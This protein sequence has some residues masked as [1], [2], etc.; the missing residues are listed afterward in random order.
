MFGDCSMFGFISEV[1]GKEIVFEE[2]EL[3]LVCENLF[4]YLEVG[5]IFDDN[6]SRM[7]REVFDCVKFDSDDS[8]VDY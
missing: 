5:N 1:V 2:I 3:V 7:W 8:W 4:L 6:W